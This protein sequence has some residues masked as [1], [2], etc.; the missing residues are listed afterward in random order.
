MST[1]TFTVKGMTCGHCVNHVTEEVKKIAGVT[2]VAVELESGAVAVTA[3]N[4]I[5]AAVMEAAVVEAGY[6]LV[7]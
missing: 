1:T 2:A 5:S 7:K 3:D 4:E 6:E